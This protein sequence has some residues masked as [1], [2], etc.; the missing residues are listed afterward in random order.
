[1]I[2]GETYANSYSEVLAILN[3]IDGGYEE[4]PSSV[5]NNF[6]INCNP[7]YVC[8]LNGDLPISEQ[9]M[10]DTTKAILSVLFRDYWA[11]EEQR[12]IILQHEK[13]ERILIESEKTN[14]YKNTIFSVENKEKPRVEII[15]Y[16][17][18]IIDKIKNFFKKL[19]NT[20]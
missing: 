17:E 12:N 14:K 16:K 1:M 5:I 7:N 6:R 10:L 15:S 18:S 8:E 19:K 4:I 2:N 9:K 11:T 3:S 13:N 20:K